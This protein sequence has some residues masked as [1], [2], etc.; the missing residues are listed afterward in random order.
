MN[1]NTQQNILLNESAKEKKSLNKQNRKFDAG[2]EILRILACLA[3]VII[4]TSDQV[5]TSHSSMPQSLWNAANIM[6]AIVRFAVPVFLMI[7][8]ALIIGRKM[9]KEKFY[10]GFWKIIGVYIIWSII[11][12]I[13]NCYLFNLSFKWNMLT[14]ILSFTAFYHLWYFKA[15][16]LIYIGA[17]IVAIILDKKNGNKIII[18]YLI[19]WFT[20]LVPLYLI[21]YFMN[22][23][24]PYFGIL[25]TTVAN[26]FMYLGWAILGFY[27]KKYNPL[28]YRI[29]AL[30]VFISGIILTGVT[31]WYFNTTNTTSFNEY[32]YSLF[33]INIIFLSVGIFSLFLNM[34]YENLRWLR[35]FG[36]LTLGI[37][38][39]HPLILSIIKFN[40]IFSAIDVL[41]N[42]S[43]G[44][45]I[46]EFL[47]IF[48]VSTIIIFIISKIPIIKKLV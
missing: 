25:N 35:R 4:H 16:I 40:P 36:K 47:I 17:P 9:S 37:Y 6:E 20:I 28:K 1:N 8:G 48:V 43:I 27:I 33:S 30:I 46:S 42:K 21:Q 29:I 34:D 10:S 5:I 45:Y 3:V 2:L 13:W 38:I 24:V 11:Y 19:L 26:F 41:K 23:K 14:D 18:A 7:S 31:V 39:I 44:V 15:V 22:I 32:A 12:S